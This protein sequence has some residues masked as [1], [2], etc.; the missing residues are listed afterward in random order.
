MK[1]GRDYICI[2]QKMRLENLRGRGA[3]RSDLKDSTPSP[4][5]RRK[6]TSSAA[7]CVTGV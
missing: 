6:T 5:E 3:V 2:F 4:G 7:F 1:A